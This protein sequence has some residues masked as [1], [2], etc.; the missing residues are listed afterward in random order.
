MR[1]LVMFALI[2]C[3]TVA[4]TT[5]AAETPGDRDVVRHPE[6]KPDG[7]SPEWRPA[8][9]SEDHVLLLTA[10]NFSATRARFPRMLVHFYA[11]WCSHCRAIAPEF[12]QAADD[13]KHDQHDVVRLA[14]VDAV[15]EETLADQL[16]V[17]GFPTLYWFDGSDAKPVDY[18]LHGNHDAADIVQCVGVCVAL[19]NAAREMKNRLRPEGKV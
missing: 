3:V 8:F 4:A 9:F 1:E 18:P 16:G 2:W 6:A 12:S 5:A 10:A 13:L 14:K 7:S 19:H 11:P 17:E 15:T